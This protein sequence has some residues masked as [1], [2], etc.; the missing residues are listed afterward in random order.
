MKPKSRKQR[1][2]SK[3]HENLALKI[4]YNSLYEENKKLK[5][6]LQAAQVQL[7]QKDQ[8]IRDIVDKQYRASQRSTKA[9][10]IVSKKSTSGSRK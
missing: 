4:Q 7:S 8:Y 1:M 3:E 10:A 9:N 2:A 6:E 5:C